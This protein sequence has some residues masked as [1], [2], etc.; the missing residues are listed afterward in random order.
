MAE[1]TNSNMLF[2]NFNQDFSCI[3]VGTRKGYSITNC[4]PF[5]RVYTMN[6]G[7][8]GIVEMLFCTSLIALVGAAD[9]P[10]SSPRKLQIVNTKRQSMICELLFPSS[11]LSVKLNRK[12]LVI[13]LENE[14]YIY[15]I[16]NMRLLHVIET[17]PNPEAICALS[18]SADNSYLA[19]PS[20]VPSPTMAPSSQSNASASAS[21]SPTGDVLIV[22]TKSLTVANV[23][24]AHKAPISFLS[25]NSTGTLLATASE[26]GT[27]I[28][29]WSI[30]GA[31]KL[32][33]FR[34][35]T[36]EARIYS[37]NFNV[38]STL[39]AVSSAHETVHIFKLGT[40]KSKNGQIPGS[41][42]E[43]IDSREG[44]TGLDG[45]YEAFIE[46]K[47]SGGVSSNL[48][49]KSLQMTKTITHS[50]GGYL[51]NTLTEMWEPSRDFAFLRLPTSGV[52][53]IAALSGT[54]PQ[55]MVIS[56]E[57]YFYSYSIDLENGGECSLMKQYR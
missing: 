45:G 6:D 33:Q 25:I 19:Y 24:Q 46:N 48:R 16:S 10:Q 49:R 34:R 36:R 15:D 50:V 47:K 11:I 17:T 44:V 7:A 54:M 39:L 37:M 38:V 32:Y 41:P 13:V 4:D 53:C 20:P 57:G 18:P 8:K 42:S 9:Q 30:P 22:S 43:S 28:R 2:V 23:I 1:K 27:V 40:Q 26:K 29:V 52:R 31:E 12:T 5:G 51:P 14:I 3:S 35:G 55:V 21:A 56:S